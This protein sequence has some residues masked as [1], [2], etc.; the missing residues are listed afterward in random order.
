MD[1]GVAQRRNPPLD[2]Q[3][4]FD[5]EEFG[6]RTPGG[7]QLSGFPWRTI[8]GLLQRAVGRAAPAQAS[9]TAGGHAGRTGGVGSERQ[10]ASGRARDG[11]RYRRESRQNYQPLQ[12]G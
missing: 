7:D 10:P 12:N 6:S 2:G 1:L 4:P 8:G 11:G 9:G 3:G 5:Q